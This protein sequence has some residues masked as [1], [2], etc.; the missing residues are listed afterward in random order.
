MALLFAQL[1]HH[2]RHGDAVGEQLVGVQ[3]HLVLHGGAAEAGIVRHALN[4]AVVP[5]QHPVLDDLQILRRA[6]GA[7]QNVAVD[8]AAGAEQR[9]ERG[10]QPG[11][12]RGVAHPLEGLL[13]HE[14]RVGAVLEVHLHRREAVERNRAQRIQSRNA[15]H[16][17]FDGNA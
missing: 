6:V 12:Q 1:L 8:Q 9:R 3:Q 15:V 13:A 11:G 14:V 2:L 17:D 10:L 4:G 5:L 7:L 16:F